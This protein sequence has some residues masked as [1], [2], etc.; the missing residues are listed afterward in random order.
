MSD[1]KREPTEQGAAMDYQ[2]H[3]KS[4]DLFVKGVKYGTMHIV[5]C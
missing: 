4:Y 1:L 2:E 3:E 5:L